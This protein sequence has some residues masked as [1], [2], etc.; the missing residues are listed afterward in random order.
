M[1]TLIFINLLHVLVYLCVVDLRGKALGSYVFY[2]I[3]SH[4]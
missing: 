4:S 3:E 1:V 2:V